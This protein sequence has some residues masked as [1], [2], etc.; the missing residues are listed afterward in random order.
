[1]AIQDFETADCCPPELCCLDSLPSSPR[2]GGGRSRGGLAPAPDVIF[3]GQIPRQATQAQ[4][5]SLM[6]QFGSV[7]RVRFI[8]DPLTKQPRGFGF[9]KF[10]DR[11][12]AQAALNE[13]D[14]SG[15][16]FW[17]CTLRVGPAVASA[18]AMRNPD[19]A[20]DLPTAQGSQASSNGTASLQT[21][22]SHSSSSSLNGDVPLQSVV[23]TEDMAVRT[24]S[25]AGMQSF[26]QQVPCM[27]VAVPVQGM[28][29]CAFLP[30]PAAQ[31]A[32]FP[33]VAPMVFPAHTAA[34]IPVCLVSAQ[35]LGLR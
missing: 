13:H 25:L 11:A 5:R 17:G 33:S 16:R 34:A 8:F 35:P 15:I 32:C 31:L 9:V 4:I 2:R 20:E 6:S 19:A 21:P 29:G 7:R 14:R 3:V 18:S 10:N 30:Q 12:S 22:S 24:A 1:M 28:G 26:A 27:P 23:A